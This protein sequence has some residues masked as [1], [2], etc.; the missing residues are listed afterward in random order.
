MQHFTGTQYIMIDVANQF[1]LD[2]LNWKDRMHWVRNH[3][4]DLPKLADNAANPI[5]YRKAIRALGCAE[6]G[7]ETN[8]MMGLDATAS[9]IQVMAIMSADIKAA[10]TV[11]LV[12][13]TTRRDL[14]TDVAISMS[15]FIGQPITREDV[16]RPVMTYFY[17]SERV[18]KSVFGE[19]K[20]LDAF[21]QAMQE[22]LP[23]PYQLRNLFLK[24]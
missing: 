4:S 14:Y 21:Y 3:R 23:G 11:N 1:G 7:I 10:E 16:K 20:G 17:G 12:D 2:R 18:P 15:E 24:F 8:H 13:P 22:T 6:K 5:A 9:G 19:A